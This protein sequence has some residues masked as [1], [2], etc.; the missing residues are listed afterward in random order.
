MNKHLPIHHEELVILNPTT[1]NTIYAL[2]RN[3]KLRRISDDIYTPN[4]HDPIEDILKRNSDKL[5]LRKRN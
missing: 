5:K 3:G 4:L 1:A 2:E